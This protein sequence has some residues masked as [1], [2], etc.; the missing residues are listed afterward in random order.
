MKEFAIFYHNTMMGLADFPDEAEA[1]ARRMSGHAKA[2][3]T[4]TGAIISPTGDPTGWRVTGYTR[5]LVSV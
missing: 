5:E 2:A 4:P 1:F 3:M